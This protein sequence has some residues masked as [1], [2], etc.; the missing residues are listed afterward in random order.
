M[1]AQD[2]HSYPCDITTFDSREHAGQVLADIRRHQLELAMAGRTR[3]SAVYAQ[4]ATTV[5]ALLDELEAIPA[6]V[7]DLNE[8]R[9]LASR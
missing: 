7:D 5:R 4:M 6:P 3:E 9:A 1:M 8:R 2:T